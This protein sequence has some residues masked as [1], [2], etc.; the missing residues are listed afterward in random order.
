MTPFVL[1]TQVQ[2]SSLH[3]LLVLITYECNKVNVPCDFSWNRAYTS[4]DF[5]EMF[6]GHLSFAGSLHRTDCKGYNW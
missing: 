4:E 2:T 5:T 1:L 6:F 3:W